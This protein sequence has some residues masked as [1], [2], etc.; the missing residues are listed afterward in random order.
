MEDL[1]EHKVPWVAQSL[2]KSLADH[3]LGSTASSTSW[4]SSSSYEDKS[5]GGS[6]ATS[7]DTAI[8][9]GSRKNQEIVDKKGGCYSY[10]TPTT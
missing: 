10:S 3:T 5:K 1:S 6:D 8:I 7:T 9:K 2:R 4:F